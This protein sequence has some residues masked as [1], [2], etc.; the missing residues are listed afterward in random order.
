KATLMKKGTDV[1]IIACGPMVSAALTAAKHLTAQKISAEVI[2]L[3]TVKPLDVKTILESVKKTHCLVTAEDHQV[4]GGMG[5]AV[6]EALATTYAAPVT[7]MVGVKGVFGESGKPDELYKK[8]GLDADSIVTAVK[9]V[10]S[11]KKR[12]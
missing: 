7:E 4:L 9:K 11:R 3:S 5:S 1:T 6:V 12:L 10:I 8:Y 2:N